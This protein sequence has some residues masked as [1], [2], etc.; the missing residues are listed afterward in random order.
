MDSVKPALATL[1][2]STFKPLFFMLAFLWVLE[3]IDLVIFGQRLDYWGIRPRSLEGLRGIVFAPVLHGGFSHLIAN[4]IPFFVLGSFVILRGLRA[5]L[6]ITAVIWLI[7]GVG[8]WLTGASNSVHIG[9]SILIFGYLGY[10][11]ARAYYE[12][13]LNA[14]LIAGLV[15]ILYGGMIFGILP[16][17]AGVSWQGHLFGFIGGIVAARLTAIEKHSEV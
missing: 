10:L 13:S 16:I 15:G 3:F 6:E 12:R 17:Q 2:N 14:L 9:A 7:G 8:T 11:L 1:Y 4:T 5:F